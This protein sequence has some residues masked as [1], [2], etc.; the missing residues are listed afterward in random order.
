[1]EQLDATTLT[2]AIPDMARSLTATPVRV[3]VAVT[4]YVLTLA[5]AG[6]LY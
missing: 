1:M 4:A 5:I 6:S 3:N 2:T